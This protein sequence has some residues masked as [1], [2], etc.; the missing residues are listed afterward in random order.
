MAKQKKSLTIAELSKLEWANGVINDRIP[1]EQ[2][3]YNNGF[4]Q[5]KGKPMNINGFDVLFN[6]LD[7]KANFA[8]KQIL[9]LLSTMN[10]N[11]NE[12]DDTLMFKSIEKF[13]TQYG[14]NTTAS[15]LPEKTNI[16]KY[17]YGKPSQ[18]VALRG[19]Y[20][21]IS[22]KAQVYNG[23]VISYTGE[24]N[25]TFLI[26]FDTDE[27]QIWYTSVT[28]NKDNNLVYKWIKLVSENTLNTFS[29]LQIFRNGIYDT[30][31]QFGMMFNSKIARSETKIIKNDNTIWWF[32]QGA[33]FMCDISGY[34]NRP[35]N[36]GSEIKFAYISRVALHDGGLAGKKYADGIFRL[37]ANDND[38]ARVFIGTYQNTVSNANSCSGEK[39]LWNEIPSNNKNNTFYALNTFLNNTKFLKS[40]NIFNY[41]D[42]TSNLVL[43]GDRIKTTNAITTYGG[44]SLQFNYKLPKT[45]ELS[46]QNALIKL[47]GQERQ[48]IINNKT[49][50]NVHLQFKMFNGNSI[51]MDTHD[52][53]TTNGGLYFS[54]NKEKIT[55][56]KDYSNALANIRN[57]KSLTYTRKD[58][59]TNRKSI[60]IDGDSIKSVLPE[61]VKTYSITDYDNGDINYPFAIDLV[62]L[63]SVTIGAVNEFLS[64]TGIG[65]NKNIH[66]IPAHAP[67]LL[68]PS[69][70]SEMNSITTGTIKPITFQ[71][72]KGVKPDY[73]DGCRYHLLNF[74]TDN[75]TA[76]F[77]VNRC[78][79]GD[80]YQH[81]FIGTIINSNHIDEKTKNAN[82]IKWSRIAFTNQVHSW[83]AW[84]NFPQGVEIGGTTASQNATDTWLDIGNVKTG[85]SGNA[86]IAFWTS[87][88]KAEKNDQSGKQAVIFAEP[89]GNINFES[90]KWIINRSPMTTYFGDKYPQ[91]GALCYNATSQASHPESGKDNNG[92]VFQS[93]VGDTQ[94]LAMF[95]FADNV[96]NYNEARIQVS[97]FDI[98]NCKLFRFRGNGDAIADNGSWV[99]ASDKRLKEN[100]VKI[101]NAIDKIN[102]ITAYT[103]NR[104]F[105][106][107]REVGIIAQDIK[108]VLP[109]A[110]IMNNVLHKFPDGKEIKNVLG[111]NY[112]AVAS[113]AIEGVKELNQKVINLENQ[114]KILQEQIEE[115]KQLISKK[116]L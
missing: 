33:S 62:G 47:I 16:P 45:D 22:I 60:I 27:N 94:G 14:I 24:S 43:T 36:M 15:V 104:K 10:L 12:I 23:I 46:N 54:G 6:Q 13:V 61:L 30:S 82:Q 81:T 20:S 116:G 85:A 9:N 77:L 2:D 26:Y 100:F 68:I 66:W 84:Q 75:N 111:V 89:N 38:G 29:E 17:F 99:S 74:G 106:T 76:S 83:E 115:L 65:T 42:D 110:V 88:F 57:I 19:N 96:N 79:N 90:K 32:P 51:L 18:I 63:T 92:G 73:Y 86:S 50:S 34:D 56:V 97:P 109:E 4:Q 69:S 114:N 39:I 70:Y 25:V 91:G 103:Y 37:V 8:T 108:K 59:V 107:N 48:D 44:G 49:E 72:Y 21:G 101:D 95:Y 105:N 112:N 87:P 11:M 41:E 58:D 52:I 71:N 53:I 28:K 67:E 102:G 78:P 5:L 1:I 7:R 80:E 31:T 113:L 64:E 55:N 40:V 35:A 98:N 93:Q 3:L